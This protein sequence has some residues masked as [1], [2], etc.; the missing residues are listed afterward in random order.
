MKS[1]YIL[2]SIVASLLSFINT[3]CNEDCDHLILKG[4]DAYI[5]SCSVKLSS[6][7]F[8]AT[9]IKDTVMVQVPNYVE[10]YGTSVVITISEGAEITPNPTSI[11]DWSMPVEFTVTSLNGTPNKYVVNIV[12][13]TDSKV[14]DGA[15]SIGSQTE[16][17]NFFSSGYTQVKNIELYNNGGRDPIKDLSVLSVLKEVNGNID[18]ININARELVF[19]N[20]TRAG[21]IFI[22]SIAAT[23]VNF[24]KLEFVAERFQI[25]KNDPGVLPATH[26]EMEEVN[27]PSLEY[28]GGSLTLYQCGKLESL[29]SL[30]KLKH[31]GDNLTLRGGLYTNLKG[32]E[33]LSTIN[34]DLYIDG[35]LESFEG[36]N[37]K[38]VGGMLTIY[39]EDVKGD[40]KPLS[41]IKY[42]GTGLTLM[43]NNFLT[44]L[45]G[46]E[47]IE[48]PIIDIRKFLALTSLE[49]FPKTKNFN[50]ISLIGLSSLES[51]EGMA[52]VE[53]IK[54]N[55]YFEGMA[56][57]TSLS[58]LDNLKYIGGG[59]SIYNSELLKNVDA[60]SNLETVGGALKLQEL[61]SLTSVNGLSKITAVDEIYLYK[62]KS[63]T[64]LKGLDNITKVNTNV[65][66]L[67][68]TEL[69]NLDDLKNLTEVFSNVVNYLR[70]EGNTKLADYSGISHLLSQYVGVKYRIK[71]GSRN[72]YNPTKQD[73]LDEKWTG[74]G[75]S[76][77]NS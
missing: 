53:Q 58:G 49:G 11:L 2:L 30:S 76:G 29:E 46:L 31:V 43:N 33:N 34:G 69:T 54:Y 70:F 21:S 32:L 48:T 38:H 8:G 12:K 73:I 26:T 28:V 39:C 65:T 45:K 68:L 62:L 16:L 44:D 5:T 13:T 17:N 1:R 9:F 25:G 40:L 59:L 71:I 61:E 6:A 41:S 3:S 36:F 10:L 35:R 75:G 22:H 20:L 23:K 57:L 52:H 18:I 55:F 14:Y 7:S 27:L 77:Y 56:K 66:I 51:L 64:S 24:P 42:I 37:V 63:L 67:T 50:Y 47:N 60:L 15:V 72:F 74:E 19:E 4:Q